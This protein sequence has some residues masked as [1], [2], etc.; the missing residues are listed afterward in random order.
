[1]TKERGIHKTFGAL[2]DLALAFGP[3]HRFYGWP[4]SRALVPDASIAHPLALQARAQ[5]DEPFLSELSDRGECTRTLTY[6]E[7][8]ESPRYF[9]WVGRS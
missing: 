1:M 3:H 5:P 7:A 4:W 8:M 6:R 9:K 2:I